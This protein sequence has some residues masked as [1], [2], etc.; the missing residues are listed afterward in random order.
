MTTTAAWMVTRLGPPTEALEIQTVEVGEPGVNQVRIAVEAFCLDF[1][2]I[3]TIRGRYGLLR[4]EPPFIVGMAAAGIV[5][6]IGPGCEALLGRRVVG[7]TAGVQGGYASAALLDGATTQ[8]I[9]AWLSTVDAMAMYFPYQVSYLA[10]RVRGRVAPGD[11]VLIHAAAGGVG[12]AAVQLAK[13]MGATVIGTAGTDEKVEFCR[14]LG[15]D[16]GVNY[17]TEDFV[18]MVDDVTNGRGVDVAFDTVGGAVT[19]QT[20]RAMAFNGRH[21]IIGFASGIESEEHPLPIQPSI[22]GNFDLVG[23]CFAYVDSPRPA[24]PFGMNFLSTAQGVDIWSRILQLARAGTIRPV[25]GQH[26]E[27][28]DV[29]AGLEALER[30]ETTG[31]TVVRMPP[32]G[33][34]AGSTT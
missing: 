17:R 20:F 12:S 11:V 30:R 2:D 15:A 10:L 22:Y 8:Q 26:I 23:I 1:N 29:P 9:P 16:F 31:R 7:T 6:A 28:G 5:E 13:A 33:G 21:L 3:D 14:S 27:F 4:F 18:A 32:D 34:R 25:I 24:R 19:T